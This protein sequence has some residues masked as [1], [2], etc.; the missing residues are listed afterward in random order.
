[1]SYRRKSVEPVLPWPPAP[2]PQ[3]TQSE[4]RIRP[5]GT[6]ADIEPAA[7]RKAAPPL[8]SLKAFEMIGRLGSIRK[9]ALALGVD[10]AGVSRHLRDLESWSGIPLM[11]R[12][13][14]GH[15][16]LTPAGM[17]YHA[18]ISAALLEIENAGTELFQNH[19]EGRIDVFCPQG[20]YKWLIPHLDQF[21]SAYPDIDLNLRPADSGT[22]YAGT[23]AAA[24]IRAVGDWAPIPASQGLQTL[25][26]L[27]P[28]VVP[29]ASPAFLANV[30]SLDK[31]DDILKWPLL[32]ERDE[33][34]WHAW[35]VK[36]GTPVRVPIRGTPFWHAPFVIDAAK[37]G[38][39]AT[40]AHHFVVADALRDGDL[41]EV[42]IGGQRCA[43]VTLGGYVFVAREDRWHDPALTIFGNWL[44]E[45]MRREI[46]TSLIC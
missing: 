25:E 2:V 23:E 43:R 15:G 26:L 46:A 34:L 9:A 38:Q 33:Q 17:R 30:P 1:M 32:L 18:R 41:V 20:L 10:H 40:L 42:A 28:F 22:D 6:V 29:V 16:Q 11:D 21:S 14:G 35:F 4:W 3:G 39:G 12:R 31:L 37:R 13:P 7:T 45:A 19:G 8:A 5:L 27:R 44:Q 36:L 24:E